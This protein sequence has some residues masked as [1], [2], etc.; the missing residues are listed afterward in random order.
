MAL[1]KGLKGFLDRHR[2][3][4]RL[5][6][7]MDQYWLRQDYCRTNMAR[8]SIN[9]QV[10]RRNP[11]AAKIP[12]DKIHDRNYQVGEGILSEE[13][14]D[15][16]TGEMP[17]LLQV[18]EDDLFT[19]KEY[20]EIDEYPMSA[21][22]QLFLGTG[23]NAVGVAEVLQLE[24]EVSPTT[25]GPSSPKNYC[26]PWV[27]STEEDSSDLTIGSSPDTVKE[28][29]PDTIKEESPKSSPST[30]VGSPENPQTP[31]KI[32]L[33]R[34]ITLNEVLSRFEDIKEKADSY[35][36]QWELEDTTREEKIAALYPR[37]HQGSC[38]CTP[39][40]R[41]YHFLSDAAF[42][43]PQQMDIDSLLQTE[44]CKTDI[45]RDIQQEST[46]NRQ[47]EVDDLLRVFE[48]HVD[49]Q[50]R[51]LHSV[52]Y[53]GGRLKSL[54]AYLKKYDGSNLPRP[55]EHRV[56]S[57]VTIGLMEMVDAMLVRWGNEDHEQAKRVDEMVLIHEHALGTETILNEHHHQDVS[58]VPDASVLPIPGAW[59]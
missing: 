56:S 25:I 12:W 5:E 30:V 21:L 48:V 47:V 17:K 20:Q 10:L 7:S 50:M 27:S 35:I 19:S 28:S 58:D 46:A 33:G 18:D 38:S 49:A 32:R 31:T 57:A 40:H 1:K 34:L 52:Q 43:L 53:S 59:M 24:R 39:E 8:E 3:Y 45:R 13:G 11:N 44:I 42:H 16:Q 15:S 54:V 23:S 36:N 14:Q 55:Q 29:S 6:I 26:E 37:M 22:E 9:L 4:Y 41:L 51:D 2:Q